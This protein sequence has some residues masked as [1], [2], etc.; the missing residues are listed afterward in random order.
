MKIWLDIANAPHATLFAP[1]A[2]ELVARGHSVVATT[3]DR[4][5]TASLALATWPDARTVGTGYRRPLLGKATAIWS[6]A[7]ALARAV[8]DERVDVAISHNSYAQILAAR[9]LR[10]R[11]VT[12]MDYEHQP[13]NHLAFRLAH[14]VLLPEVIPLTAMRRYGLTRQK[15]VPY[16]G[17]KEDVALSCFR[18][19]PAFR[20]KLDWPDDRPV[21]VMRPAAEGALYHRKRNQLFDDLV[22][23]VQRAGAA[24]VL[25]P[26][27]ASQARRYEGRPGVSV[28][29]SPVSG[30][31]LLHH[32]DAVVGAGGTM[33]REAAVLG[34]PSYSAFQ[35]KPAAVDASLIQR[36]RLVPIHTVEDLPAAALKQRERAA[37]STDPSVLAAF[38]TLLLGACRAD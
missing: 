36:G 2:D 31:D 19:D 24:V 29:T 22:A 33:T 21:V 15:A 30:P 17:L 11:A 16:P 7:R 20:H 26:R 3:W 4:G 23:S 18:P 6:R 34:T 32:A 27:T 9:M 13:A 28:L 14:R 12:A 38:T 10:V 37:P 8:A 1:V 5:Q 35:G 25:S